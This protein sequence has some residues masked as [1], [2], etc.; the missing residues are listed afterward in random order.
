MKNKKIKQ[1][2]RTPGPLGAQLAQLVAQHVGVALGARA[3]RLGLR[4]RRAR[5]LQLATVP[6]QLA[7]L[8]LRRLQGRAGALQLL[9]GV[10]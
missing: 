6:L 5:A 9:G 3:A 4:L 2:G 8:A 10:V 1:G 7:Q